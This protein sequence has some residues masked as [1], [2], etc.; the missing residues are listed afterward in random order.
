MR[1]TCKCFHLYTASY[2]DAWSDWS[3]GLFEVRFTPSCLVV[4]TQIWMRMAHVWLLRHYGIFTLDIFVC[5]AWYLWLCVLMCYHLSGTVSLKHEKFAYA[6]C[7]RDAHSSAHNLRIC[8]Y[9]LPA[10]IAQTQAGT[11]TRWHACVHVSVA[12]ALATWPRSYVRYQDVHIH[13]VILL[14][15]VIATDL[16]SIWICHVCDHCR[17]WIFLDLYGMTHL[18]LCAEMRM[19]MLCVLAIHRQL[20]I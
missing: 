16:E 18:C 8:V 13:F 7:N 3:Y 20:Q 12:C 2:A 19:Y 9:S 1:C 5:A 17:S 6:S 11:C 4:H 15:L 10:R 14:Y